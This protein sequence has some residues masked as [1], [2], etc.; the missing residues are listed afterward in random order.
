MTSAHT[1]TQP[2][3]VD[4]AIVGGAMAGATLAL[5]LAKLSATLSRP[6]RIALIEAHVANNNHRCSRFC[7]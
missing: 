7:F 1:S 2:L 6:L 4:I 5:G 3:A